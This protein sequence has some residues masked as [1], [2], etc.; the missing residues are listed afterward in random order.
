MVI[1]KSL[2]CLMNAIRRLPPAPLVLWQ[3]REH[4]DDEG[5]TVPAGWAI[6]WRDGPP[7]E[8]HPWAKVSQF[9]SIA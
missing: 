5:R 2:E 9:T 6:D 1:W 3:I 4:L 7:L 8:W